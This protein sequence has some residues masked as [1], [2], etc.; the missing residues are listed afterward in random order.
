[1]VF[2]V[3]EPAA[4]EREQDMAQHLVIRKH[5]VSIQLTIG[6]AGLCIILAAR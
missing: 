4:N 2:G 6:L 3:Q 1:V 5:M